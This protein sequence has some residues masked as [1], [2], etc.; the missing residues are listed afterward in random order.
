MLMLTSTATESFSSLVGSDGA[1]P[2]DTVAPS[3]VYRWQGVLVP[4]Q[5]II[6]HYSHYYSYSIWLTLITVLIIQSLNVNDELKY[7][8]R[9]KCAS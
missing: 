2:D 9:Q 3:M 4:V 8:Q 1:A 7:L 5:V 6:H